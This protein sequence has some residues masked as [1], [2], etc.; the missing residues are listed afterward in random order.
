MEQVN[1]HPETEEVAIAGKQPW[2]GAFLNFFGFHGIGYFY[3]GNY[4]KGIL[5]L[6]SVML[7]WGVFYLLIFLVLIQ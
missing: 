4:P 7:L 5:A 1:L 6:S 2:L 3:S